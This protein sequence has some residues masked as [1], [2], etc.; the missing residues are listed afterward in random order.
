MASVSHAARTQNASATA[1]S[2]LLSG[3]QVRKAAPS[4]ERPAGEPPAA[5]MRAQ[6][7]RTLGAHAAALPPSAPAS[8]VGTA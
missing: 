8:R 3:A 5:R 7:A 1:S 2:V 4:C 6:A